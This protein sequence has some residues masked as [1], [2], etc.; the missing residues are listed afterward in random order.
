MYKYVRYGHLI[1]L[2]MFMASIAI[3]ITVGFVPGGREVASV[4][5][6]GRQ[7]IDISTWALTVPGL[8]LLA[9]SGAFMVVK[10]PKGLG[11][12][13]WLIAHM[14]L[15]ALAIINA[16]AILIPMG[17]EVFNIAK[18]LPAN[19][20]LMDAYQPIKLKESIL[21]GVNLLF[22]LA[23]IFMATIKPKFQR[24]V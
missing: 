1:G 2:C 14:V 13:K 8:A 17:Q 22:A 12:R 16:G 20:D 24:S 4:I 23:A 11:Q 6:V 7:L 9:I 15:A 18:S 3:H 19:S 5:L 10:T 21:G